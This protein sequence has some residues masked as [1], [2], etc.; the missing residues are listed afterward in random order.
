MVV[1]RSERGEGEKIA[2]TSRIQNLEPR[3]GS[4]L[5]KDNGYHRS[6]SKT[7]YSCI[8]NSLNRVTIIVKQVLFIY[9]IV[10]MWFMT[11]ITFG[12]RVISPFDK[13]LSRVAL[14]SSSGSGLICVRWNKNSPEYILRKRMGI[15]VLAP[16][17]FGDQFR[18]ASEINEL[19]STSCGACQASHVLTLIKLCRI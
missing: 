3:N 8:L 13:Q 9:P 11:P 4:V 2:K 10:F 15:S 7:V 6:K 12:E 19:N 17:S 18:P 16:A 5:K 14:A 1:G